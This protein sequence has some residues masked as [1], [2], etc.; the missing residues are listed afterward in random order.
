MKQ[1]VEKGKKGYLVV[2]ILMLSTVVLSLVQVALVYYSA[3]QSETGR[4]SSSV[5]EIT[6]ESEG[7]AVTEEKTDR[8][9]GVIKTYSFPCPQ[10]VGENEFLTFYF[11]HTYADIYINDRLVYYMRE[12]DN[13]HIGST[14]GCYW[15]FVPLKEEDGTQEVR[16]VA[17][18]AYESVV[19][20]LPKIFAAEKAAVISMYI[21]RDLLW[22]VVGILCVMIGIIFLIFGLMIRFDPCEKKSMLYLGLFTS[23]FSLS[24]VTDLPLV[25]LLSSEHMINIGSPKFVTY[26]SLICLMM[27]PV[28]LMHF[29]TWQRK[30]QK[31]YRWLSAAATLVCILI[32]LMQL[33]GFRDLRDNLTVILVTLIVCIS[34]TF[35]QSIVELVHNKNNERDDIFRYIY[36]IMIIGGIMDTFNYHLNEKASITD[37]TL[38][39]VMMYCLIQCIVLIRKSLKQREQLVEKEAEIA[40]QRIAM[41]ISQIRPHFIYNTMNTIYALCDTDTDKAK[42]AIHD[43]SRYLRINFESME[44]KNP[45]T[46]ADE[47][48]YVRFYLSIEK[49]RFGDDL[50]VIYDIGCENFMLPA[51]S[52]QP[53]VEN[54]VR[55]GLRK[56]TEPGT[57]RICSTET[58]NSYM[59]IVEDD[60]VGFNILEKEE[61]TDKQRHLGIK[62]VQI[63]L[64]EMCGGILSIESIPGKGTRAIITIP[65]EKYWG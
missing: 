35:V 20:R 63:R 10:S 64:K 6:Q 45:V 18:P 31:I 7:F 16:I 52:V 33:T 29:F 23:F 57:I 49:I 55:H 39:L 59:V 25:S 65:K 12:T 1:I 60:G 47:L 56:K 2:T 9:A 42:T 43:F 37:I 36:M 3:G 11:V 51:L 15:A 34:I 27:L 28:F 48:E 4:N 5:I 54:A 50:T 30:N 32:S 44:K 22:L 17:R 41:T 61:K 19:N 58:K 40:D 8:Y 21:Q 14:P 13:A 26:V 62:N 38:M 53:I 24:R 46:F